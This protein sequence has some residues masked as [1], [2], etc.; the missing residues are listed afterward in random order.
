MQM[1]IRRHVGWPLI[2]AIAFCLYAAALLLNGFHS[3]QQLRSEADARLLIESG[4]RAAAVGDFFAQLRKD[5]VAFAESQQIANYNVNKALGM[6]PRYGLD[7]NIDAISD[8]FRA[9]QKQITVRN[10]AIFDR[11]TLFDE[12][13]AVLTEAANSFGSRPDFRQSTPPASAPQKADVEINID[14]GVLIAR[15]PVSYRGVPAGSIAADAPISQLNRYLIQPDADSEYFEVLATSAGRPLPIG[16]HMPQVLMG[17]IAEAAR[18]TPGLVKPRL[19]SGVEDGWLAVRTPIP[20]SGLELIT[21]MSGKAAYGHITSR[22]IL[23]TASIFPPLVLVAAIMFQRMRKRAEEL[24]ASVADSNR[25]RFELQGRN[26]VLIREIARRQEVERELVEKARQ[27][28]TMTKDLKVSM[29]RAEDGSRAKSEFL[30]TMSHEIRTPMNG[31]IGM[32]SL[33]LGADLPREQERFVDTIRAS[34]EALL[35]IIN[36]ILDFSKLETRKLEFE[37][38]PFE[39]CPLIHGIVNILAPRVQGAQIELIHRVSPAAARGVFLGDAGRLRQVLLNLAGNA[40]KFTKHGTVSID[41]DLGA[42]EAGRPLFK[43]RITDTG[44][45]IAEASKA[46]LFKTFSQA[47]ASTARKY[48]GS[49]L[50]LAISKRIVDAMHGEIGFESR[51]GE[52][53]LF[54][55]TVPLVASS[56]PPADFS[57]PEASAINRDTPAATPR[58]PVA[59]E[60]E[61][62]RSLRVLVVDDNY[63]NQ[64]VAAGLLAKMG[65]R[66]DVADDGDHAV[67]LTAKGDY[68]LV[69]MDMQMPRVDGLTAT[70]LIRALPPPINATPIIA[71]TANALVGDRE[72][73]LSAGMDDYMSKPI[74]L[75]RLGE[76]LDSWHE[77]IERRRKTGGGAA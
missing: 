19:S 12:T 49:G 6:S 22:L 11:V 1:S 55:F 43:A 74:N 14:Q 38:T 57:V 8:M 45:G 73:C 70:R 50:G 47:D 5:A 31:I 54:W 65:H 17:G 75:R 18:Q 39:I 60:T 34:A 64:Q 36:D 4:R 13:G 7:A 9:K 58:A 30:A 77:R 2:G 27:L 76:M 41:I 40:V 71:V 61:A 42:D 29:L 66:V 16:A 53:S 68:D 24:Q 56:Q 35:D 21:L 59:H 51:E 26:E 46:R 67:E 32:T 63:V 28:E 69:L 72:T 20:E 44:I 23:Y 15:A 33:L 25:R 48:G 37:Q 52:G 10:Q 62:A 3:E